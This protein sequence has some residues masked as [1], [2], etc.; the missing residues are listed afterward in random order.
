[1]NKLFNS[2]FIAMM[3]L[4]VTWSSVSMANS[5][6]TLRNCMGEKLTAHTYNGN[7]SIHALDYEKKILEPGEIKTLSCLARGTGTCQ[8]KI[9]GSM[10]AGNT[11]LEQYHR[12]TAN[13]VVVVDWSGKYHNAGS[14]KSPLFSGG[15]ISYSGVYPLPD[16]H[17]NVGDPG[18]SCLNY[19]PTSCPPKDLRE[20]LECV[21]KYSEHNVCDW[22]HWS[23]IDEVCETYAFPATAKDGFLLNQVKAG[24]CS[25][26]NWSNLFNQIYA[27]EE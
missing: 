13:G 4:G 17:N 22:D 23:E 27:R 24:K 15:S 21:A 26:N 2:V 12:V 11:R 3:S 7:D 16:V 14:K 9:R 1:M 10:C 6:F 20:A 18:S 8:V 5:S 19:V 25:W